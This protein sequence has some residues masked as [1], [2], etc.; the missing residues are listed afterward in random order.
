[1]PDYDVIVIGAGMGGLSAGALLAK[2]GKK[3]LVLEQSERVGGCC[4][5]FVKD[6]FHFDNGASI[7]EAVDNIDLVFRD[8]DTSTDQEIN[9][10]PCDPVY[11]CLFRDGK[12]LNFWLSIEKTAQAISEISPQDGEA[13]LRYSQKFRTFID[14]G[15]KDFFTTPVNTFQDMLGLMRKRPVIAKFLPYFIATYQDI[16]NR[17]FQD[18]RIRQSMSY[19]SFYAG[20]P[21]D[22]TPGIFAILPFLEHEGVYYPRG[23][24]IQI[25]LALQRV[26]ERLGMELRLRHRVRR[27]LT[28]D[29]LR[30]QGVEL[31]DGTIITAPVVVSNVNA[32]T[33]YLEM[34]GEEKLPSMVRRGVKSYQPSLTAPMVFLGLDYR[35][36][37]DAHHTIIPLSVA[38]MNDAW[39]NHYNFGKIPPRQFGLICWP[40]YTDRD[41]APEGHHILNLIL[42]GPYHLQGTTWDAEKP[43]FIENTIEFLSRFCLPGLAEHVK[44]AD[45][46]TP[47]DYERRLL[48]PGGAIYGLQED[49]TA[50]AVFRPA[51]KSKCVQGLYLT[52]ASTHPGGGVPTSMASGWIAA[53]SIMQNPPS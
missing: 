26:G 52:G 15:G 13:F 22:L 44:V 14:E 18:E 24:M 37:L 33:L 31:S 39:W 28:N 6:G 21:P 41:L 27:V 17:F 40:T 36:P 2:W 35:P 19:Q 45:M 46:C 4:S 12:K 23:G 5:T 7:V 38:E 43:R 47:L 29:A 34:I 11:T 1:M 49:L 20:H 8:L 53:R 10:L 48:L 16:I 51:G 50:Q 32:R 9:L 25:P 3:V 30:V 42:M